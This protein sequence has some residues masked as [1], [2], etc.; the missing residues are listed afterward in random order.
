MVVD[1]LHLLNE[2]PEELI[3]NH[4]ISCDEFD[5][6]IS[7]NDSYT[8]KCF[9]VARQFIDDLQ[10]D[11]QHHNIHCISLIERVDSKSLYF[12]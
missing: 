12:L 5:N 9:T 7:R 6:Y 2:L 3:Q 11:Y 8:A 1:R 10:P 4:F